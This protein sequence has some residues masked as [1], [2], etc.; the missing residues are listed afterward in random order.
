MS[1]QEGEHSRCSCCTLFVTYQLVFWVLQLLPICWRLHHSC[2]GY[3]TASRC[4]ATALMAGATAVVRCC[5]QQSRTPH[6]TA[7]PLLMTCADLSPIP[8]YV[9]ARA[10]MKSP[11]SSQAAALL[12]LLLLSWAYER[13]FSFL[14]LNRASKDTPATFTTCN[15]TA[16]TWNH[17][18]Y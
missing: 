16:V 12:L 18:Q 1:R 10:A 9:F 11:H 8:G 2:C 3:P 14:L 7:A 15:K 17:L 4:C 5:T 6:A 13:G